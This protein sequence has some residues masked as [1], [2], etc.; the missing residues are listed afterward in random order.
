MAISHNALA[1]DAL[2]REISPF[3]TKRFAL[4]PNQHIAISRH[5]F[6]TRLLAHLKL[7]QLHFDAQNNPLR[8]PDENEKSYMEEL[9]TH[10]N[11]E[12]HL[13]TIDFCYVKHQS[14]TKKTRSWYNAWKASPF[15]RIRK[16]LC[17]IRG[18]PEKMRLCQK[19][20]CPRK[21]LKKRS[22]YTSNHTLSVQKVFIKGNDGWSGKA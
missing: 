15:V 2:F 21:V 12:L 3:N 22:R 4:T 17:T 13:Q 19:I 1:K 7:S 9:N 16:Y 14:K 5:G 11:L 20:T 6:S 18:A 10:K 8:T